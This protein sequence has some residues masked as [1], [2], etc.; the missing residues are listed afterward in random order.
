MNKFRRFLGRISDETCLHGVARVPCDLGQ[1]TFLLLL[2][3]KTTELE[4]K[5]SCKNLEDAELV[6]F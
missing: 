1:E 4:V 5:N 2:S 6:L 3:T